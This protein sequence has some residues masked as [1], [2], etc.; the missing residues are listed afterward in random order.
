M[1]KP[2][3]Y[4]P[5]W[6]PPSAKY[7]GYGQFV[8][9][10]LKGMVERKQGIVDI[11][12][13]RNPNLGLESLEPGLESVSR[14]EFLDLDEVVPT[15]PEPQ[16]DDEG[17]QPEEQLNYNVM[18][19][20]SLQ[21]GQARVREGLEAGGEVARRVAGRVTSRGVEITRTG[22][23]LVGNYA[24][25][26]A[27]TNTEA[28]VDLASTAGSLSHMALKGAGPVVATGG[29]LALHAASTTGTL[30]LAAASAGGTL[31]LAAA[32]TGGAVAVKTGKFALQGASE[33]ATAGAPIV[34]G[35]AHAAASKTASLAIAAA[36]VVRDV[37]VGTVKGLG[38]AV[39]ATG[40]V[41]GIALEA[42]APYAQAAA[43]GLY[44]AAHYTYS[45]LLERAKA[46]AA[47]R[48]NALENEDNQP[49]V[50]PYG[51]RSS[52]PTRRSR[53]EALGDTVY[54]REERA[55]PP[56]AREHGARMIV[57]DSMQDWQGFGK[58]VLASQIM[59]RP[60]FM[61]KSGRHEQRSEQ[62]RQLKRMTTNE[63]IQILLT[64]DGKL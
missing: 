18:P 43:S 63:M 60:N 3:R 54:A 17:P 16:A 24:L 19:A 32:S 30:G 34:F 12:R 42:G 14:D 44:G 28:L 48:H 26:S 31:G 41:A 23:R 25:E 64:L 11:H 5:G 35:A 56:N 10:P 6:Y 61:E 15:I 46:Y 27:R 53:V 37:T 57:K 58:G 49:Y 2:Q 50:E 33:F 21:M 13:A 55:T 20:T 45:A 4:H 51:R 62:L 7:P 8:E 9:S 1:L 36:P 22:V 29:R 40:H 59:L 47:N 38:N 39:I 52:T